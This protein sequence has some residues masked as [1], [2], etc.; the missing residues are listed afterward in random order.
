[1]AVGEEGGFEGLFI[2]ET[3]VVGTDRDGIGLHGQL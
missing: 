1:V 3:G 2:G